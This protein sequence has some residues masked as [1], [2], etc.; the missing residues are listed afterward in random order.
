VSVHRFHQFDARAVAR[1][2]ARQGDVERLRDGDPVRAQ[3][4]CVEVAPLK[5]GVIIRHSKDPEGPTLQ[6]TPAEWKAFLHGV[7]NREFDF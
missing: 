6:Y 4:A 3:G 7:K 1:I 2:A 5:T